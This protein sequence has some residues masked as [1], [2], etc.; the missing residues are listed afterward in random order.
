MT[1]KI[2]EDLIFQNLIFTCSEEVLQYLA[3][4]LYEKDLVVEDYM[5][6]V[7]EREKIYPT[8]LP[9]KVNVA[10]PHTDSEYVKETSI[11][12]GVLDNPVEFISMED[13]NV[14]LEVSLVIMLAIKDSN[15]Q[16]SLLQN[17]IALIQNDSDVKEIINSSDKTKIKNVLSKY[18]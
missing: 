6:A 8:G 12:I 2:K 16:I 4:K 3:T 13:P 10:I 5:E 11:A 1:V 9:A 18:I 15:N 14:K 7:V 17:I